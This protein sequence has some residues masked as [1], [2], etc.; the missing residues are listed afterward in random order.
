MGYSLQDKV[1]MFGEPIAAKV[2]ANLVSQAHIKRVFLMDLH[3]TSTPGFFSIPSQHI[4]AKKLFDDYVRQ[5]FDLTRTVIASP[6]FGGV[7]RARS[8]ATDL[9]IELV[10]IDKH[11]DL[12]TGEVSVHEL[13]GNVENKDV[14]LFDDV[15]LSGSTA[16]EA[17]E[18][19]K[20]KGARSVHML[21]SHLTLVPGNQEK[22]ANSVLDSIVVTNSIQHAN[23]LPPQF[24]T[25]NCSPVFSEAI[26]PWL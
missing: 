21:A 16:I 24:K 18:E 3:N 17:G 23:P 12:Q 20:N 11:R 10:K 8:F 13:H 7:K 19:I 6:D 2:V 9:N 1:F 26:K 14:L 25:L 4:S 22:L 5:N 15:I